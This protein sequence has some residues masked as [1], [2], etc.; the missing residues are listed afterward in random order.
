MEK[1][2]NKDIHIINRHSNW[3]K[4]SIDN[5]LKKEIYNSKEAWEQF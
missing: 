1:I 5:L 3:S 4:D 2:Q